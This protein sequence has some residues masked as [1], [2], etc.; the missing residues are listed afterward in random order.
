M[1]TA[2]YLLDCSID[3]ILSRRLLRSGIFAPQCRRSNYPIPV[4]VMLRY[5]A[6][7]YINSL[8]SSI[9]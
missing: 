2:E 6:L 4:N 5:V 9:T 1:L 3:T 8:T 7:Y